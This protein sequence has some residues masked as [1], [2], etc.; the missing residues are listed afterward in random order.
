MAENNNLRILNIIS[1]AEF[2]GAELFF[3]R[4][5]ISFEKHKN[6]NQKVIIRSNEKRFNS[7]KNSIQNIEQ[8]TILMN[9]TH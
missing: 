8:M 1:G 4:I 3:E 2:G 9:P 5:A 6:I 7:L